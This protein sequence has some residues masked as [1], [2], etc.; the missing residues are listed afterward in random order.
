MLKYFKKIVI[1]DAVRYP[2]IEKAEQNHQRRKDV[3]SPGINSS[4]RY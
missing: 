3:F 1:K 2:V 4:F